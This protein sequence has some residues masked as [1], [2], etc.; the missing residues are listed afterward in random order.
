[1]LVNKVLAATI[2]ILLLTSVI[3]VSAPI[4]ILAQE[5]QS[6]EQQSEEQEQSQ[7]ENDGNGNG[8]GDE[9]QEQAA[10]QLSVSVSVTNPDLVRGN[11]QTANIVTNQ[12]EANIYGYVQYASGS[13]PRIIVGQTD[14]AGELS[15]EWRVGSGSTPGE[16][17]VRVIA[18]SGDNVDDVATGS[19]NF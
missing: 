13:V 7:E 6:E 2:A 3:A 4:R 18:I 19:N 15:Y 17:T 11:K 12:P 16:F 5:E 8:N 1:M 9:Q 10:E 14:D